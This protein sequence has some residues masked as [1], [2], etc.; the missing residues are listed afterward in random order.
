M[1]WGVAA[2]VA[3]AAISAY[4]SNRAAGQQASAANR[5]TDSQTAMFNQVQQN[6]AP[7]R[8]A[9][10]GALNSLEY[11]LGIGGQG[12]YGSPGAQSAGYGGGQQSAPVSG[13]S[14]PGVMPN[15]RVNRLLQS[16][17]GDS[18]QSNPLASFTGA[19]G[20]PLGANTR[21]DTVPIT[22]TPP[23]DAQMQQQSGSSLADPGA[24]GGLGY[25][26]L[27][28]QF[29]TSDLQGNLAPN[30]NFQ[31]N[32]GLGQAANAASMGGGLL[33]GNALQGLNSYAQNYAQNAYQQ[34]F[35][36]YTTNQNNIAGRLGSLAQLGQASA[37]GSA[38]GA[39]LFSQGISQTI[40]GAGQAQASGSVGMANALSSGLNNA[41][42]YYYL[43]QNAGGGSGGGGSAIQTFD[44]NQPA[45]G[46]G[47]EF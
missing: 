28:H 8:G 24:A 47:G 20:M 33:G 11:L 25:G 2:A 6:L 40:Q 41:G 26:Y 5:A 13:Q 12:N 32:Q 30:Y 45:P 36:N 18:S 16:G 27:T 39:P 1:P 22:G 23:Q 21:A 19:N 35:Q 34:A 17:G 42:G 37:T 14:L 46:T 15:G 3:G 4:G 10:V 44:N 31:L 7:Y 38:S 9:G 43:N 29:N